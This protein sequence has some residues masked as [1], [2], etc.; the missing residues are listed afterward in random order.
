MVDGNIWKVRIYHGYLQIYDA[1]SLPEM[2]R[3]IDN[4]SISFYGAFGYHSL[5]M[6]PAQLAEAT[7][8][9]VNYRQAHYYNFNQSFTRECGAFT[10]KFP[11]SIGAYIYEAYR[12]VPN[13]VDRDG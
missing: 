1:N 13:L 7:E 5:E 11:K 12:N 6:T 3:K 4:F 9:T 10:V 8:L 2:F